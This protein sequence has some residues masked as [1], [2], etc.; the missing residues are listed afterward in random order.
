MLQQQQPLYL[1]STAVFQ[2]GEEKEK[3]T[4]QAQQWYQYANKIHQ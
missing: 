1:G 3:E 4:E 2:R